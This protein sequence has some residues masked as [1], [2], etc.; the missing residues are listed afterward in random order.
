M[1]QYRFYFIEYEEMSLFTDKITEKFRRATYRLRQIPT[2]VI[3]SNGVEETVVKDYHILNRKELLAHIKDPGPEVGSRAAAQM[4]VDAASRAE[5]K[6][7]NYKAR[8]QDLLQQLLHLNA[9]MCE[10]QVN[11]GYTKNSTTNSL[12]TEDYDIL[13]IVDDDLL[14]KP[15]PLI[16]GLTNSHEI[17]TIV[18]FIIAQRGECPKYDNGYVVNLICTRAQGIS[19]FLL[20]G[21]LYAIKSNERL[22]QLGIL[23]LAGAFG[24]LDGFCAYGN[25]GFVL[26]PDI[27]TPRIHA[28]HL[29]RE[30]K[31]IESTNMTRCLNYSI[32]MLPMSVNLSQ[33]ENLDDIIYTLGSG[34]GIIR[35][36]S[37][38]VCDR[39][40]TVA[41]KERLKRLNAYLYLA[42]M[43]SHKKFRNNGWELTKIP[44]QLLLDLSIEI[45]LLNPSIALVKDIRD[46]NDKKK[47]LNRIGKAIEDIGKHCISILIAITFNRQAEA[48]DNLNTIFRTTLTKDVLANII[49]EINNLMNNV[50]LS[51]MPKQLPPLDVRTR[52]RRYTVPR[53]VPAAQPYAF[54][55]VAKTA[56]GKIKRAARSLGSALGFSHAPAAEVIVDDA[57]PM[58]GTASGRTASGRTAS[59]RTASGRTASG[60]TASGRTASG[61]RT[62]KR[63]RASA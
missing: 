18:G 59:G 15:F 62:T 50:K 31:L 41:E 19:K 16:Q 29:P 32:D 61:Q 33:Y 27:F 36:G 30:I 53:S 45:K 47:E 34:N 10:K 8:E 48:L 12:N 42:T 20:G 54:A 46:L 4:S 51:V 40:A 17:N 49:K 3:D 23:E 56:K 5:I 22:L 25:L 7:Q 9:F 38:A 35:F 28:T 1:I 52:R 37:G 2:K 63:R 60:R 14:D 13:A 24:N 11:R 57:V 26:D 43:L 6:A 39:N 21:Y 44:Y 55:V 58:Q